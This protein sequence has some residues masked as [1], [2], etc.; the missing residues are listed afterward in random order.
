M[1]NVL[2][3]AL[4]DVRGSEQR[5][6]VPS[7]VQEQYVNDRDFL[8]GAAKRAGLPEDQAAALLDDPDAMRAEVMPLH[9]LPSHCLLQA[10][11]HSPCASSMT[12]QLLTRIQAFTACLL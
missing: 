1:H 6:L 4:D 3:Q 12:M 10:L 2:R 9:A 11:L 8:L 7:V 5:L